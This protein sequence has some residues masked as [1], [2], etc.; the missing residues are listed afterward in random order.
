MRIANDIIRFCVIVIGLGLIFAWLGVYNTGRLPFYQSFI[1]WTSTMAVG[2]GTSVFI[3]PIV[4]GPRFE[5][6]AAIFKIGVAAAIISV[7]VTLTLMIFFSVDPWSPSKYLVQYTYVLVISLIVTT[8]AFVKDT[9][10]AKSDAPEQ[11]G[12]PV[13]TFMERLPMKFHTADLHAISSEDHYLRVHTSLGEELILM[14]LADAVRELAGADGLQVHRSWWI[15]KAG[16]T[17]EKKVDGRS[18]LI[19]PSGTEVPVSRSYKAKAKEAGLI[20]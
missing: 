3:A 18:L 14:R 12:D 16:I 11:T 19:L 20:R 6:I 1:F 4:W 10:E 5:H 13:S 2:A 15:A 8:A 17:D 9:L 7:P